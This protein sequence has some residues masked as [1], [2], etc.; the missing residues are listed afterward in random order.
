MMPIGPVEHHASQYDTLRNMAL[1]NPDSQRSCDCF[2]TCLHAL[3]MLH[4]QSFLCSS[5][6]HGAPPFD[7]VLSINREAIEGCSTML[8]CAN[9]VSKCGSSISTMLLSTIFGKVMS[10][11]RAACLARSASSA[12]VHA[13]AQMTFGAY[14]VTGEDR[15]TMEIEVLLLELRRVEGVLHLFQERFSKGSPESDEAV[16]YTALTAYLDKNLRYIVDFLQVRK[17]GKSNLSMTS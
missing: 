16:V 8:N 9:C 10:L 6:Q 12:N 14:T 2:A 1:G 3:H 17:G 5:A 4:T 11:Y 15:R 7:I 13:T